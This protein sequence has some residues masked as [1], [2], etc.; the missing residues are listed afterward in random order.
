MNELNK[1][2]VEPHWKKS[3]TCP[4][5]EWWDLYFGRICPPSKYVDIRTLIFVLL[6]ATAVD[7]DCHRVK[8]ILYK[9]ARLCINLIFAHIFTVAYIKTFV[10]NSFIKNIWCFREATVAWREFQTRC[11]HNVPPKGQRIFRQ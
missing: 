9:G 10:L 5:S 6:A 4:T 3:L 7:N 1:E 2:R 8:I 11:Y